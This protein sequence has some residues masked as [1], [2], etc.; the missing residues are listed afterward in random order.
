MITAASN[1]G[2]RVSVRW[3][4]RMLAGLIVLA[5]L[6]DAIGFSYAIGSGRVPFPGL[7]YLVLLPALLWFFRV[8]GHA[9]VYGCSPKTEW[10]PFASSSVA[11]GYLAILWFALPG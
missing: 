7:R 3:P 10:W 6:I 5:I 9:V 1:A 4:F 11:L 8:A 2:A